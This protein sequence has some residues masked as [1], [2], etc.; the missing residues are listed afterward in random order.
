VNSLIQEY[1]LSQFIEVGFYDF[2]ESFIVFLLHLDMTIFLVVMFTVKWLVCV[3]ECVL[4]TFSTFFLYFCYVVK[5]DMD[6]GNLF[7]NFH[8]IWPIFN[9]FVIKS[10]KL[11]FFVDNYCIFK[12]LVLNSACQYSQLS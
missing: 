4:C 1:V 10:E 2:Q 11:I 12:E 8:L 3:Y 5:N 6:V 7:I 9:C